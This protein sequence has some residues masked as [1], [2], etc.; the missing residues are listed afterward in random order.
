[1]NKTG[2]PIDIKSHVLVEQAYNL[3]RK[4]EE[5]PA[6]E[7]QTSISIQASELC[8]E[9]NNFIYELKK[10][11]VQNNVILDKPQVDWDGGGLTMRELR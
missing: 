6:S 9:I 2:K 8:E 11:T 1:M 10:D 5:L 3:C 4:I 7:L